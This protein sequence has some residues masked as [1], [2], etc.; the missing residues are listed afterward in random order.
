MVGNPPWVA[1]RQMS[2]DLQKRFRDLVKGESVH[3]VCRFAT[4]SD[5]CALFN[6]RAAQLY[7]H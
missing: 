5:L 7:L 6:V 1:F 3:V 4:Q 2:D